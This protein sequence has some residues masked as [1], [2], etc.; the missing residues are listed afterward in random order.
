MKK[1]NSD[2]EAI[3]DAARSNLLSYACMMNPGYRPVPHLAQIASIM[4]R[5]ERGELKRVIITIP[6]RHGKSM[7][8]SEFFPAWYLGRNPEKYIITASYG[9]D[10]S[11]DFGRKVRNQMQD[12][13]YQYL[14][15]RTRLAGDSQSASRFNTT[16]GGVYRSVGSDGV[17]TGRGAHLFLIDDPTKNR[18]D[19]ESPTMRRKLR[20][21]YSSTAYTRLM[22]NGAIVLIM[23]RWNS[24]DIVG[25]LL[26][27]H[28]HENWHVVNMPVVD[29]D[30][31][32]AL[33]A[34]QYPID[35]LK[36]IKK[37]VGPY[38]WASQYM[39]QPIQKETASFAI[40]QIT[41][42][43]KLPEMRMVLTACDPAISKSTKACNTAFCT[44][45][46]AEDGHIY[47]LETIAGKWSFF[48]ILT[49][50]KNVLSRHK[51]SYLGV[52]SVG[53]QKALSEACAK[54][55][56]NVYV[57]D[58]KADSDKFRRAESVSHIIERGLFHTNDRE[59]LN[60]MK[61]FDPTIVGDAKKDRVD[62][63]VHALHMLQKYA[64][65]SFE[66]SKKDMYAGM[67][68]SQIVVAKLKERRYA[69]MELEK[70]GLGFDAE[71]DGAGFY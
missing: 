14:F 70:N 25:W 65:S 64:P 39:Q 52:E 18:D 45:G 60:E 15:P 24:A 5:V 48:E 50:A 3:I 59:L 67:S 55:F 41:G 6:P 23:Q 49:Q 7:L 17:I 10:L 30:F 12:P 68:Q 29:D 9:Q 71:Y 19:A 47:D 62:A 42:Y 57:I 26:D 38:N 35:V 46:I 53:F 58:L 1:I 16:A 66:P 31:A 44:L 33:W 36:L 43:D 51:S 54:Y 20:D 63:L 61:N 37:T 13:I 32:K 28:S 56:K 22:P 4:H 21:W 2:S 34:D 11:D 69:E 8:C 27:E 40:E